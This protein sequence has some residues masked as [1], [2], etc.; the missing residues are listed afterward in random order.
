MSDKTRSLRVHTKRRMSERF[1][2]QINRRDIQAMVRAIQTFAGSNVQSAKFVDRQSNRVTRWFVKHD[3]S[4][5]PVVYDRNRRTIV[6]ILP[7]GALGPIPE[8][9]SQLK[10]AYTV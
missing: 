10:P 8:E 4:W 2:K 5:L 9:L 7:E 1:G 6:T 3:G